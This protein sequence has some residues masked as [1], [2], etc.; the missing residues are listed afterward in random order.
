MGVGGPETSRAG[1]SSGGAEEAAATAESPNSSSESS[2]AGL[3]SW[4]LPHNYLWMIVLAVSAFAHV[5]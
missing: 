5:M 3:L 2:Q 1:G 4:R